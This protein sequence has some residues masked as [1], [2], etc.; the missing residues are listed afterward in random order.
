MKQKLLDLLQNEETLK[1]LLAEETAEKMQS[2]CVSNGVDDCSIEDI[3]ELLSLV[4][5]VSE[6]VKSTK[7]DKLSDDQI[8]NI[9]GGCYY[10]IDN[11]LCRNKRELEKKSKNWNKLVRNIALLS[12]G[13]VI[14]SA[15]A[16]G[17]TVVA[18]KKLSK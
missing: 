6:T 15:A 10:D 3:N 14:V 1:K 7:A 9:A 4:K 11:Y 16:I 12:C 18:V 8:D 17:G 5:N 13:G 2:F